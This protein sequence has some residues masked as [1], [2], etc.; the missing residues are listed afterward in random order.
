M[1]VWRAPWGAGMKEG[2]GRDEHVGSRFAVAEI[3]R[4]A[5]E[6]CQESKEKCGW[7][8]LLSRIRLVRYIPED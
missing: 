5:L 7:L 1:F 4:Y 3:R 2:G 8:T 6:F